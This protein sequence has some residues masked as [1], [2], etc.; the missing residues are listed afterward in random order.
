MITAG[1]GAESLEEFHD[2]VERLCEC[3]EPVGVVEE[4]LVQKIAACWWRKARVIRAEN[5]E[6]RKGQDT[7]AV[8]RDLRN[9]DKANLDLALSEMDLHL[10]HIGNQA[11]QQV[12]TRDRWSTIQV[13]QT[14]LRRNRSGL[15]Y[16]TDLLRRRNVR[17]RATV[18]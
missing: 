6:I 7:L 2:M 9:S 4:L 8:D 3:Y 18:T 10:F 13:A 1:D 12:S 17:S 11:D 5:G 15:L 16:L 14:D